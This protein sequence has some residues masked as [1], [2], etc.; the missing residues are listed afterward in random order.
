MGNYQQNSMTSAASHTMPTQANVLGVAAP[1][2]TATTAEPGSL[3]W[4]SNRI[5]NLSPHQ[6]MEVESAYDTWRSDRERR[7]LVVEMYCDW[8]EH[9]RRPKKDVLLKFY[10]AKLAPSEE[11]SRVRGGKGG[12]GARGGAVGYTCEWPGCGK[13]LGGRTDRVHEHALTHLNIKMFVCDAERW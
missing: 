11:L 2:P 5:T 3:A 8:F 10:R 12:Q 1:A 4:L 13:L 7:V 9:Q 6:R